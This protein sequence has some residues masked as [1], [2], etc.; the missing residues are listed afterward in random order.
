MIHT[1]KVPPLRTKRNS[2]DEK[3]L[4]LTPA[5]TLLA[6]RMMAAAMTLRALPRDQLAIPN[7]I[8]SAWPDMI[9]ESAILY[10]KTR[11]LSQVRPSPQAIDSMDVMLALLWHLDYEARQLV[12]ARANNIPWRILVGRCGKSRS[13]L[14]RDYKKALAALETIQSQHGVAQYHD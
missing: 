1:R 8:R 12:W 2:I 14:N 11:R 10:S 7:G 9:R 5:E 6:K 4:A 3:S 13:S